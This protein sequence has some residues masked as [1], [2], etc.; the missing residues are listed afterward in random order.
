[1]TTKSWWIIQIIINVLLTVASSAQTGANLTWDLAVVSSDKIELLDANG[2]LIKKISEQFSRLKALAFDDL[3]HQFIAS[4]M[5]QFY[6]NDTIFTIPLHTD[7]NVSPFIQNLPDDVQGLA[8][9][10]VTDTLF[11][12]D[13]NNKSISSVRLDGSTELGSKLV[14]EFDEETPKDIAIDVCRR[15]IYW[16]NSNFDKPT[17]E[18]SRLDGSGREVLIEDDLRLPAGIAIDYRAQRLYWADMR[19]GIYFRIEG[20]NLDGKEREIV[21]EGTHSKPF[22][23]AVDE[24]AIYFTDINNNALWKIRKDARQR[25]VPEKIKEFAEQPMGVVAKNMELPKLEDCKIF[26]ET[27]KKFNESSW[28]EVLG[29]KTDEPALEMEEISGCLNY[30]RLVDGKSCKCVRGFSGR[31]C[32]IDL[33]HNY[34][35]HGVCRLHSPATYPKCQCDNGF[36]GSRCERHICDGFCLNGGE[37]HLQSGR[38]QCRCPP[39]FAGTRCQL[40]SPLSDDLCALYCQ[41]ERNVEA[42]AICDC[43]RALSANGTAKLVAGEEMEYF[44][45]MAILKD[46]FFGLSLTFF[47]ISVILLSIIYRN[48]KHRRPRIKK[49]IIVN[50]NITPLTYRPQ[51]AAEQCEITI[52]DCCN[53]N[54]CETPCF[55]PR[56]ST[57]KQNDDKKTL[58]SNMENGEDLY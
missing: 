56:V 20:A 39:D 21:Y 1:M 31:F 48:R 5:D 25:S 36:T 18:R 40:P 4:D 8:I 32:E 3:R 13:N 34:C 58:L 6:T 52:E 44:D 23:L 54:V 50:K 33:C 57:K 7:R 49:R 46:P 42:Q 16:T 12:T 47:L 30:G 19:E 29:D 17:I 41:N 51:S 53:M 55:E 10:P 9:D 24:E 35:L 28:E 37:C 27:V 26:E 45:Y 15:R 22:G 2:N 11:W 14:L 38:A 43:A